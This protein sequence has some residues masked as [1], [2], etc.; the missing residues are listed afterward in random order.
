[1]KLTWHAFDIIDSTQT[2]SREIFINTIYQNPILI[3][4]NEQLAGYGTEGSK[5]ESGAGNLMT[6]ICIEKSAFY[7]ALKQMDNNIFHD[8]KQNPAFLCAYIMKM[9]IK[10]LTNKNLEIKLP[11]D[12]LYQN[13]KCGGFLITENED[14][15]KNQIFCIGIGFN[16]AH[17]PKTTQPT[18]YIKY[19]K[20]QLIFKWYE[21][22]CKYSK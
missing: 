20:I 8:I 22:W 2:K 4:A 7:Q 11:N 12:L 17:A 13:K 1:M 3:T 18:A 15:A 21:Y 10:D 9:A 6:T 16:C 14:M 5:W 19:D